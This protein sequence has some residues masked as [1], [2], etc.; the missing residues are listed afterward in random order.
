M[1]TTGDLADNRL[2]KTFAE[3]RAAGKR[4]V[5]PFLTAGYPDMETTLAILADLE[6]RGVRI[7]E[8]GIPFSDPIADGPTIQ[9]SFTAALAN[10]LKTADVFDAVR[11]YRRSGGKL[12]LTAMG[13]YSIARIESTPAPGLPSEKFYALSHQAP[14]PS[15][16]GFSAMNFEIRRYGILST[17]L[18]KQGR[19]DSGVTV[20]AG[21][22]KVFNAF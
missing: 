12:A 21:L 19:P 7:C 15:G 3:L 13:S 2:S 5:M 14:M 18:S 11:S 4:T 22:Y 9:A 10:G 20:E 6:G 17:G 16:S 8:L 1:T